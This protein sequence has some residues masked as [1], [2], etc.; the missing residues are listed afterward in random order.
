MTRMIRV[1]MR[2]CVVVQVNALHDCVL[3]VERGFVSW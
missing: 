2:S 3:E 1:P